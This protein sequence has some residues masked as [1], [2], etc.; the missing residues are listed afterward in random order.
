VKAVEPELSALKGKTLSNNEV[1]KAAKESEILQQT[2]SREQSAQAEATLLRARQ[3]VVELD[4]DIT[5]EENRLKLAQEV[6]ARKF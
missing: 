5:L 2:V 3:R 1:L 6:H 4:K